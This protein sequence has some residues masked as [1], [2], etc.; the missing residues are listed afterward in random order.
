RERRLTLATAESCTGGYV[1]HR[2][3]TVSGSSDY[4]T[5]SVVAY[6][7]AVKQKVLGVREDTLRRHG[8]VSEATVREMVQGVRKAL[9]AYAAIA[10]SG[11]AGP[12]GGTPEKPVGT[13]WIAAGC[14]AEL[15]TRKLQLGTDRLLNIQLTGVFALDLLRKILLQTPPA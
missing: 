12:T 14:G 10:T 13:I 1:A 4:F 15:R 7:N 5:G 9:G 8:A 3:T 2:I 11:I 6:S